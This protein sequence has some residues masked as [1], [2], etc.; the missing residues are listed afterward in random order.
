[1][2]F[3]SKRGIL[4]RVV[5]SCL[6]A[7]CICMLHPGDGDTADVKKVLIIFPEEGWSAPAYRTVY[8][9]IKHRFD[10]TPQIEATLF[11]ESLDLYLFPDQAAQQH[12][13]EFLGEKYGNMK[14]DLIIP[15]A[16]SSLNFVLR[17]RDS[18]FSEI[19]VV[20]CGEVA[21]GHKRLEHRKGVTGTALTLDFAGTIE[22]AR[23]LQPGLKRIAVVAGT[24]MVDEYLLSLFH[25]VFNDYKEKL[26][27]IDLTGL[28]LDS[29]LERVSRLPASTCIL[30][31]TL[32]RD[33]AGRIFSSAVTQKLVS[34]AANA[35]LFS[36]I[37]T[38]LGYGTVGGRMTQIEAMGRKTGEIALRVL[39]GESIASIAPAVI[40]DNP[41]MFDWREIKRWGIDENALPSGSIIRFREASLWDVYRW[42]VVG[43]FSFL[44]LQTLLI[45]LLVNNLIKRKRAEREAARV[46][47]QLTHVA[48]VSTVGQI[49]QNLA[50]EINQPLAAIRMNAEA[51]RHMLG[52]AAPDLAQ[53]RES[54]DDIVADNK[55]AEGVVQRIRSLVKRTTPVHDQIDLNRIAE[56]T[57]HMI[58]AD[59]GSK[60]VTVDLDL[61]ND[62]PPVYG[63]PV[64]LEQVALNLIVNAVEA[65]SQNQ[66]PSR[67]VTVKTNRAGDGSVSLCVSD[68]G[69]GIDQ[70]TADRLFEPF[71]TTKPQGLGL[72]LSI[73]RAIAEAHGGSL[74]FASSHPRGATF[75]LRLPAVQPKTRNTQQEG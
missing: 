41:A 25:D 15:V 43:A 52:G 53:V 50:H 4:A 40:D 12:L 1:M 48:R 24:G 46:R 33:G 75:C 71:F 35:P 39:S 37:D 21:H 20:Y 9:A 57:T 70:I 6:V 38:A 36:M 32:Q 63:D 2:R 60:D 59:A 47:G 14:I 61:A 13:A 10:E 55:R 5:F 19:P 68:T 49:G 31:L 72:G 56:D 30:Y 74:S 22:L 54:L 11:G 58:E 17:A 45:S 29:L 42:W 51:A 34:Q 66:I 23:A 26:E 18:I 27:F 67:V 64:Q 7:V 3:P 69:A 44:C 65:V 16:H 62:L 8:D 73:S 28:P